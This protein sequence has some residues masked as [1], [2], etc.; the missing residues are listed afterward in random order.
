MQGWI[1][2]TEQAKEL[3]A[4]S[5]LPKTFEGLDGFHPIG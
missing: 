5:R 3:A 1:L 2:S 4:G